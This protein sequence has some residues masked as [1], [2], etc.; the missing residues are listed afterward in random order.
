MLAK[1]PSSTL[2]ESAEESSRARARAFPCAAR[3]LQLYPRECFQA[4][5]K[6][7]GDAVGSQEK[8]CYSCSGQHPVFHSSDQEGVK[9]VQED[10][11]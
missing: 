9:A 7:S 10:Q 2:S 1:Q 5:D 6:H 8:G 11:Q 4:Q 3:P